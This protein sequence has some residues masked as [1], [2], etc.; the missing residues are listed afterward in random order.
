MS[1]NKPAAVLTRA[2]L[3]RMLELLRTLANPYE[4]PTE[5]DRLDAARLASLITTQ[6]R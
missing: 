4:T 5:A 2:D 6:L 3:V 1:L